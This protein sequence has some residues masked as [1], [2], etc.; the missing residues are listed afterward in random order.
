ME[1][2]IA[3]QTIV[4][5]SIIDS[6]LV[7]DDKDKQFLYHFVFTDFKHDG[8]YTWTLLFY[9]TD[10]PYPSPYVII[11]EVNKHDPFVNF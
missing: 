9:P 11:R 10:K 5:E 8:K 4:L 1:A 7:R 2:L 6:Y 3:P